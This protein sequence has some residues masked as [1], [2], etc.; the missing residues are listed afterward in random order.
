MKAERFPNPILK[1]A[2][3]CRDPLGCG[4]PQPMRTVSGYLAAGFSVAT[5]RLDV[6]ILD[7]ISKLLWIA[8][9]FI[10][11]W[12][13][14]IWFSSR[15]LVSGAVLRAFQTGIPAVAL[16]AL[17]RVVLENWEALGWS[18]VCASALSF[19]WWVVQEALVWGRMFPL[20]G[21]RF[22]GNALGNFSVFLVSGLLRRCIMGSAALLLGLVIF[23]P[24]LT[25]PLGEW[26]QALPD[27]GWPALAG[28]V[29]IAVLA[30]ALMLLDALIRT[31]ALEVVGDQLG[32]LVAVVG[33]LALL[34][35]SLLA[36]AVLFLGVSFG[37]TS[38]AGGVSGVFLL[39][40]ALAA[41]LSVA[42]SYLLLVRYSSV[43][44][45]RSYTHT[46]RIKEHGSDV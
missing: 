5:R 34:E 3:T 6:V 42:H 45:M 33:T 4:S 2:E 39:A 19:G 15:A 40:L 24:L 17:V 21:N 27:I 46:E 18:L 36:S 26:G 10:L 1:D 8:V 12:F 44:I 28:G 16:A 31:D 37:M 25:S 29:L 13:A 14:G 32:Q 23:G 38:G 35:A 9:T 30:F 43:G 22:Y 11:F 7:L 41:I 20:P